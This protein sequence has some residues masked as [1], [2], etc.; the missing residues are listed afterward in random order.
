MMDRK[1]QSAAREAASLEKQRN[2]NE[3]IDY[4]DKHWAITRN[5]SLERT[6]KLDQALG[7]LSSKLNTII[8]RRIM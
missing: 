8:M 1:Q 3:I 6:K 5:G 4:L 2:Y 7:S